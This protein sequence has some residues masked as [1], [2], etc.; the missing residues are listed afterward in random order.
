[1]HGSISLLNLH[2]AIYNDED[3]ARERESNILVFVLG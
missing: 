3:N 2:N 1:M